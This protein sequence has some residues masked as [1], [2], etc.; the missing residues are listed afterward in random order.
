MTFFCAPYSIIVQLLLS[1]HLFFFCLFVGWL[2]V[3]LNGRL[4]V[5]TFTQRNR[6]SSSAYFQLFLP[7]L[8]LFD[9]GFARFLLASARWNLYIYIFMKKDSQIEWE[10][11]RTRVRFE[12]KA[13]HMASLLRQDS[14]TNMKNCC[15]WLN[16][17]HF[18]AFWISCFALCSILHYICR[19][20]PFIVYYFLFYSIRYLVDT[21]IFTKTEYILWKKWSECDWNHRKRRNKTKKTLFLFG[22]VSCGSE[23]NRSEY[24]DYLKRTSQIEIYCSVKFSFLFLSIFRF[25]FIWLFWFEKRQR[26]YSKRKIT[27]LS[28][29]LY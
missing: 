10:W 11:E 1:E 2:A 4:N 8:H 26:L 22:A 14:P 9:I 29:I 7:F 23:A 20:W 18:S 3:W 24:V 13:N 5:Y 25:L 6:T 28:V 19:H 27:S 12:K 17:F 15:S 16:N 21:S